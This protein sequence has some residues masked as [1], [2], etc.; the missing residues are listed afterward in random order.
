MTT[1]TLRRTTTTGLGRWRSCDETTSRRSSTTSARSSST[2]SWSCCAGRSS[3]CFDRSCFDRSCFGSN[4]TVRASATR[5]IPGSRLRRA[6]APGR[7]PRRRPPSAS[8]RPHSRPWSPRRQQRRRQPSW[9]TTDL[10]GSPLLKP[11]LTSSG[12]A[13]AIPTNTIRE[14]GSHRFPCRQAGKTGIEEP[15]E[16]NVAADT[17][18]ERVEGERPSVLKSALTAAIVGGAAAALTY[19]LLRRPGDATGVD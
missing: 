14:T 3:S 6:A 15:E 13:L 7:R 12:C 11:F 1:G 2:H 4:R 9:A 16:M 5:L 19:R 10:P 8:S 18:S 17:I